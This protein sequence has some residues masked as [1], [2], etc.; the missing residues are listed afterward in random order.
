[1]RWKNIS[2]AN[3]Q[4]PQLFTEHSIGLAFQNDFHFVRITHSVL[5][6]ILYGNRKHI[7]S[8]WNLRFVPMELMLDKDAVSS[9]SCNVI[10]TF[11]FWQ[12]L[13]ATGAA[14]PQNEQSKYAKI[15]QCIFLRAFA[16][17][18]CESCLRLQRRRTLFKHCSVEIYHVGNIQHVY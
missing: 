4:K 17:F 8:Q 18:V 5:S 15:I 14:K 6:I 16:R 9:S 3:A 10:L 1:M 7:S 13:A 2:A 11:A 12:I